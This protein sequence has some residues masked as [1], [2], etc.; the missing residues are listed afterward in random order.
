MYGP[1]CFGAPTASSQYLQASQ[2]NLGPYRRGA[3]TIFFPGP[4]LSGLGQ[5]DGAGAPAS[6]SSGLDL[7]ALLL[8]GVGAYLL[9]DNLFPEGLFGEAQR[10]YYKRKVTKMTPAKRREYASQWGATPRALA[11]GY[12]KSGRKRRGRS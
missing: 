5:N 10:A 6:D 2:A 9:I 4:G 7:G 11:G 12:T 3:G 8:I 1:S